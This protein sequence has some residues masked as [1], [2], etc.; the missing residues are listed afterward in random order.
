MSN[1]DKCRARLIESPA[2]PAFPDGLSFQ[3]EL[4]IRDAI[5]CLLCFYQNKTCVFTQP[6]KDSVI[7]AL[8]W[9][10]LAVINSWAKH[11]MG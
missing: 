4:S 9:H 2:Q 11:G 5:I 6:C 1:T 10:N 8:Q 3:I 7:Q